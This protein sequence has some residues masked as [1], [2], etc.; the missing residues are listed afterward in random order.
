MYNQTCIQQ[1]PLGQSI[2]DHMRQVTDYLRLVNLYYQ[3]QSLMIPGLNLFENI[4]VTLLCCQ[5]FGTI[6]R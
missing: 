5:V 4:T 2:N 3:F 6:F 1:L